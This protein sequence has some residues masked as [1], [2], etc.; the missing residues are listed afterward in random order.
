M[1][2]A[3]LAITVL[4][5][6]VLSACDAPRVTTLSRGADSL[7]TYARTPGLSTVSL[8]VTIADAD[9]SGASAMIRS[10]GQG[11][12]TDGAQNV[13]ATISS[14]GVFQ[15]DTFGSTSPKATAARW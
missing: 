14:S 1:R 3:R 13:A 9:A 15:F 12:Y 2:D 5:L 10:D 8:T 4:L 6:S 7:A 11:A